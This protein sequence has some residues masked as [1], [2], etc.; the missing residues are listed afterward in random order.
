VSRFYGQGIGKK[1][2]VSVPG[3]PT[4]DQV[5]AM[6]ETVV[7][8][9]S[10]VGNAHLPMVATNGATFGE[11][12]MSLEDAQY[13]ESEKMNLLQAA[14]I[15]KLPPKFL[16]GEGDL[17]EW[18]FIYLN[19]VSIAPRL[20]RIAAA[21]YADPDL[22]PERAL[23]PEFRVRDLARTDAKTSAEVEHFQILDGTLL[24]DEARAERGLPPLRMP[25]DPDAE[26][27]MVPLLTPAGAGANKDTSGDGP[28]N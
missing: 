5:K 27:G 16:T 9:Q 22:F 20:K 18:D 13:V 7:A 19:T 12:G 17:S 25:D 21:L 28:G 26:P 24:K 1:V 10:G 11:A 14:H 3:S 8:N 2:T 23:Y 4:K 15:F 6:V